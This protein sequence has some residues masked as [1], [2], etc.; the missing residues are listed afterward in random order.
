MF[1]HLIRILVR[2]KKPPLVIEIEI[3][4]IEK[5]QYCIGTV[6]TK[7]NTCTRADSGPIGKQCLHSGPIG[8]LQGNCGP[9]EIKFSV[10]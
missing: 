1:L 8:I 7:R 10:M 2:K 4:Q 5:H 3:K 9:K 6:G